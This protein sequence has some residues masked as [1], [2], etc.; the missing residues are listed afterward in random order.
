VRPQSLGFVAIGVGPTT[1]PLGD[2]IQHDHFDV[3]G[4]AQLVSMPSCGPSA[5]EATALDD[6]TEPLEEYAA[7]ADLSAIPT[8][9]LYSTW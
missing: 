6:A 3:C 7:I 5:A 1:G 9:D 4:S 2:A 8:D